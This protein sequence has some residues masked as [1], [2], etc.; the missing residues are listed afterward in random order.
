MKNKFC[1]FI[2]CAFISSCVNFNEKIN[3]KINIINDYESGKLKNNLI[4]PPKY[5]L[6]PNLEKQPKKEKKNFFEKEYLTE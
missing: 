3:K 6:R 2:L 4:I 1:I 5:N